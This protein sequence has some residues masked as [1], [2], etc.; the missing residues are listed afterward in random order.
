MQ[1]LS[2]SDGQDLSVSLSDYGARIIAIDFK[3]ES[4]ALSY[5]EIEHYKADPFY[6]GASIGPI[7]NRIA[8]GKLSVHGR[9]FQMPCNEGKHTLHSGG[10][11]FD[12][13]LWQLES[14][15]SNR[16]RYKLLFDLESV[17]LLGKLSVMADYSVNDNAL[18][19]KYIAHCDTDTYINLTNHVY[20]NLNGDGN[21]GGD[22]S[23]HQFSL[24]ADS[25][26]DV[27]AENIPNGKLIKLEQPFDYSLNNSNIRQ[28][29]GACDHHFNAPPSADNGIRD[30]FKCVSPISG[31]A[32]C[33]ASNSPG[34]QFY[35]GKFLSE[36]FAASAGFCVET[37]LAPD[38]INQAN[39]ESPLLLANQTREQITE[40]CF[41]VRR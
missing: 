34:F 31:I 41:S 36:P 4:L 39:L 9:E 24:L 11:A 20:L 35:T 21:R 6:L 26:V 2:I 40:L 22:I 30:V 33:V 25:F 17:G 27:D 5:D 12:K 7:T 14:Q 1:N 8:N 32:L 10:A 23:N 15:Q 38:A 18:T 16:A 29:S 3:G 13:H 28:F 37:Q 19:I